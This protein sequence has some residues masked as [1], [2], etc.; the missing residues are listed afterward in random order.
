MKGV[1]KSFTALPSYN[2][3]IS[4]IDDDEGAVCVSVPEPFCL[5]SVPVSI[6]ESDVILISTEGPEVLS[7]AVVLE[8]SSSLIPVLWDLSVLDIPSFFDSVALESSVL[9]L[10]PGDFEGRDF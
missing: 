10:S 2:D 5:W 1:A 7:V 3:T 9:D 4:A 8:T 6:D